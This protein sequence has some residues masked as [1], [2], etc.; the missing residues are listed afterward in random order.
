MALKCIHK[1]HR[2]ARNPRKLAREPMT[3]N[4]KKCISKFPIQWYGETPGCSECLRALARR[5]TTCRE[6]FERLINPNATN[7]TPVIPSAA[8]DPSPTGDAVSTRQQHATQLDT[9]KH[10]HQSVGVKRGAEA[11]LMFFVLQYLRSCR[12]RVLR[13][14][15]CQCQKM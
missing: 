9:L 10:V 5:T 2:C 7:V 4:R 14:R 13:W 11:D 1:L 8:G 15:W 3:E 12:S 6:R